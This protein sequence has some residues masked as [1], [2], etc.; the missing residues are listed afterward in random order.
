MATLQNVQDVLEQVLG[1]RSIPF[2]YAFWRGKTRHELVNTKLF[3]LPLFVPGHPE[4]SYIISA[5]RGTSI[6]NTDNLHRTA[7]QLLNAYFSQARAGTVDITVLEQWIQNGCPETTATPLHAGLVAIAAG[8]DRHNEYWRAIDAFFLPRHASPETR[9]HVLR[10]YGNSLEAWI[11]SMLT[12]EDPTRWAT[13][14]AQQDVADSLSYIRHHQRRLIQAYYGD[15]Q[16]D[17]F[18][19]LWKF[20]ACLL[21]EDD[22]SLEFPKHTMNG[23]LDWFLWVP[24]LDASLRSTDAE[25]IDYD[26]ARGW[27]LVI[28]ADGLLRTDN[29]RPESG[30]MP[31]ADFSGQ[32]P[33]LR[34]KVIAR[35]AD[36]DAPVLIAEMT[37]RARE[38]GLFG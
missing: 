8:D 3:G 12:G 6:G 20:G 33:E 15:S 4:Q 7:H 38:S 36:A 5:L 32:D 16:P 9:Q 11:P 13:F 22:L 2:H 31:I 26:L 25:Q 17:L 19:S 10:I 24:Y 1:T 21:P 30:R 28:I 23:V 34:A 18:D 35:Y 37:R 27:Q 29:D 14:L